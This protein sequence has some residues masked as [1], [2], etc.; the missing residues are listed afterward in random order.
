VL[1]QVALAGAAYLA[2][3][4]LAALLRRQD[5]RA[6]LGALAAV[7]T[8]ALLGGLAPRGGTPG[9]P[10]RV[11]LVQDGGPR[12]LDALQVPAGRVY[13]ATLRPTERLRPSRYDLV[14]WPEDVVRLPGPLAA[15]PEARQ[16]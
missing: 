9:A 16:L 6:G 8:L 4:A 7:A 11:A 13:Q 3:A 10:V 2:G 12:G 14:V 5:R 15:S 1:D